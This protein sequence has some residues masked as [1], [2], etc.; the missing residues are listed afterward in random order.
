EEFGGGDTHDVVNDAAQFQLVVQNRRIAAQMPFPEPVA[1]DYD[2]MVAFAGIVGVVDYTA[3]LSLDAQ[4]L[5][6]SARY[7]LNMD[8]LRVLAVVDEA[9]NVVHHAEDG[10]GV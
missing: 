3:N 9:V 6:V 7:G 8:Q 4:G 2:R 5:K 1:D 10:R